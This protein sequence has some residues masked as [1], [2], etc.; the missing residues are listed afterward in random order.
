MTEREPVDGVNVM[1]RKSSMAAEKSDEEVGM[2]IITNQL[3]VIIAPR[4][5]TIPSNEEFPLDFPVGLD[6]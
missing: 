2:I 5:S 3:L 1:T 4:P 6:D